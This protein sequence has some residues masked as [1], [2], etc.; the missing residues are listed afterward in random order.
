MD[1]VESALAA[2]AGG[3]D[4]LEL[5]DNLLEGGT[6]PSAAMIE[7]CRERVGIPIFMMIRPRGGDFLY[8]DD[9]FAVM[10]RDVERAAGLGAAGVVFGLLRADGSVDVERTRALTELARPLGVTFH[11]AFDAARDAD[12]AL[13]ALLEAGVD[14]VLTSGRAQSAEAGSAVIR[15]MVMRA[16]GRLSVMAGAGVGPD[17]VERII[18]ET[19]VREVHLRAAMQRPSGM[20]YRNAAVDFRDRTSLADD[21]LEVT[22]PERIAR[23]VAIAREA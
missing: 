9:E 4:R 18:R 13:D 19:G 3:A 15:G 12:A 2:E 16:E 6:T 11:R 5:C 22:D 21:V 1:T 7:V 20:T 17:N 8:S 23:V 14:R 10:R